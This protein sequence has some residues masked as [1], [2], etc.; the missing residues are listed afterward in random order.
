MRRNGGYYNIKFYVLFLCFSGQMLEYYRYPFNWVFDSIVLHSALL[1]LRIN[2][3]TN[4]NAPGGIRTRNPSKRS[5]ADPRL[6]PIDHRSAHRVTAFLLSGTMC[7]TFFTLDHSRFMAQNNSSQ[8]IPTS[9]GGTD[10][11]GCF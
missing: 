1:S 6:R 10:S 9:L 7:D 8:D 4:I 5:A 2:H 11:H 3:N